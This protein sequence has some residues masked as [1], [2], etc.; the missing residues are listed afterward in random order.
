MECYE[1]P[2]DVFLLIL[3]ELKEYWPI[4]ELVN[5]KWRTGI[6]QLRNINP[7][8]TKCEEM[9]LFRETIVSKKE[10]LLFG[11]C[12]KFGWMGDP[13]SI[14]DI[15]ASS[16]NLEVLET[17]LER[18]HET[19][20]RLSQ[21][22]AKE[23]KLDVLTWIHDHDADVIFNERLL[24]SLVRAAN[25]QGRLNI[26]KFLY[27]ITGNKKLFQ[28]TSSSLQSRNIELLNWEKQFGIQLEVLDIATYELR[29]I[30]SHRDTLIWMHEHRLLESGHFRAVLCGFIAG[31][32][33]LETLKWARSQGFQWNIYSLNLAVEQDNLEIIIWALDNGCPWNPN[34]LDNANLHDSI[35]FL[36]WARGRGY[37]WPY[38]FQNSPQLAGIK[39]AIECGWWEMSTEMV[40]DALEY[41]RYDFVQWLLQRGLR[42]TP[43]QLYKD[44]FENA[45]RSEPLTTFILFRDMGCTMSDRLYFVVALSGDIQKMNWLKDNGCPWSETYRYHIYKAAA[46]H[47][48][49]ELLEWVVD[50][51]GCPFSIV[52]I[53]K[54]PFW[55]E[56]VDDNKRIQCMEWLKAKERKEWKQYLRKLT[57]SENLPCDIAYFGG[58]RTLQWLFETKEW[59]PVLLSSRN[60][61]FMGALH[62]GHLEMAHWIFQTLGYSVQPHA[63][64]FPQIAKGNRRVAIWI[65]EHGIPWVELPSKHFFFHW[66]KSA[67]PH[68]FLEQYWT[69]SPCTFIIKYGTMK[70]LKWALKKGCPVDETA[71]LTANSMDS[72]KRDP[73]LK[74]LEVYM[75]PHS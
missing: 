70:Q 49:W 32:G 44:T 67:N 37:P 64:L 56:P 25:K 33:S 71:W 14:L 22:A 11:I 50:N 36:K 27:Q 19:A 34:L 57:K 23:G 40:Q 5:S 52:K 13:D 1:V 51:F 41:G 6:N 63:D 10:N 45:A 20:R 61:L 30:V 39:W 46:A 60:W 55:K 68:F 54:R 42:V 74:M 29:G 72:F 66:M 43:I 8:F 9:K 62:H 58:L 7:H 17:V 3:S 47:C 21:I 59:R 18:D 16:G 69:K 26:L 75:L 38:G 28:L 35:R 4:L 24:S 15:A 12:G 53:L 73:I 65:A 2:F 31:F 48:N